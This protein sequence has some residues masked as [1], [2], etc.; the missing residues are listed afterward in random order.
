MSVVSLQSLLTSSKTVEV[1]YSSEKPGFKVKV[2]FLSR[3]ELLKLRKSCVTTKFDKRTRQPVE[4]LNED[5][6]T[7]AY[8]SA[9]VKGWSGLK[10]KYLEDMCL[11]DLDAHKDLDVELEFNEDNALYLMKNSVEFDGFITDIT[12]DLANFRKFTV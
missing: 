11:V 5:L 8:V 4:E 6:F 7:K 1:D 10:L 3:E 2:A 12:S 9:V